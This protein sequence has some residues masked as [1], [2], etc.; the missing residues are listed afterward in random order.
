MQDVRVGRSRI[1]ADEVAAVL[2]TVLG[3]GYQLEPIGQA[4]SFRD[5]G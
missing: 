2:G 5:G 4:E 1:S 3:A